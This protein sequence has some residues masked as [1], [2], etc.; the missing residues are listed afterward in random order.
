VHND[1]IKSRGGRVDN[2]LPIFTMQHRNQQ[3]NAVLCEA[4]RCFRPPPSD[5]LSSFGRDSN[6]VIWMLAGTFREMRANKLSKDWRVAREET[7]LASRGQ[8]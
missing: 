5:T 6:A 7:H 4:A 2:S 8:A 3:F 1:G